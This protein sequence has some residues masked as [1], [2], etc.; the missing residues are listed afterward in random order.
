MAN[1]CFR[2]G[3]NLKGRPYT[4]HTYKKKSTAQKI[5]KGIEERN[6][7]KLRLVKVKC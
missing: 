6:N 2:Y 3:F 1:K 7:I 5:K 4:P